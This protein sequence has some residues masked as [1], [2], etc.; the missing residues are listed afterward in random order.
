[1]SNFRSDFDSPTSGGRA[2]VVMEDAGRALTD[3]QQDTLRQGLERASLPR[4]HPDFN[5]VV[6]ASA[7]S[8]QDFETAGGQMKTRLR[9]A[10]LPALFGF[11]LMYGLACWQARSLPPAPAPY[12]RVNHGQ[13]APP[14]PAMPISL[15]QAKSAPAP[16]SS[17]NETDKLPSRAD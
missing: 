3:A 5:A 13:P 11:A 15:P 8:G 16:S 17:L 4:P 1:M 7:R 9:W 14:L 12:P 10:A 2:G 6:L